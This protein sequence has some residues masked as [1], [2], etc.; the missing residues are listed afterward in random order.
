MKT[1]NSNGETKPG[2][3]N[4]RKSASSLRRFIYDVVEMVR[5][6]AFGVGSRGRLTAVQGLVSFFFLPNR[7]ALHFST[8][9]LTRVKLLA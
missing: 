1:D 4:S 9:F 5:G 8:H 6:F 3:V 2:D 7:R